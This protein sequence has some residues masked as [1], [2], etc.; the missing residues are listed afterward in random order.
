MVALL[1]SAQV[2]RISEG[3]KTVREAQITLAE[4]PSRVMLASIYAPTVA[5]GLHRGQ[6]CGRA[7]CIYCGACGRAAGCTD[8][9][10][11]ADA[12][13]SHITPGGHHNSPCTF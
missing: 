8:S 7:N 2:K 3:V 11:Y 9:S 6:S 1:N 5:G 13:D 10:R 4:S 12:V